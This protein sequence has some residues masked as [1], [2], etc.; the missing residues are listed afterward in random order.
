MQTLNEH[1]L[2]MLTEYKQAQAQ[3]QQIENQDAAQRAKT[4]AFWA[5]KKSDRRPV[6]TLVEHTCQQCGA[7]IPKKSHVWTNS[8]VVNG[9]HT[10]GNGHFETYY[11][12][13]IC[14]PVGGKS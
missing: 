14:K 6:K 5:Q 8:V 4:N 12:C 2:K 3:R 7:I 10:G 13:N 9:S 1:D 11:Y